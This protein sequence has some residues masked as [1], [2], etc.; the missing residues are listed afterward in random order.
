MALTSTTPLNFGLNTYLTV[1]LSPSSQFL[2]EPASLGLIHPDLSHVSSLG[3]MRDVQIL[4]APKDIALEDIMAA[5]QA[6]SEEGITKIEIL[7]EPR[8]RTKRD[9]F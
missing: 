4:S 9:E 8:Q 6:K 3:V 1:Y 7:K 2:S 5:L